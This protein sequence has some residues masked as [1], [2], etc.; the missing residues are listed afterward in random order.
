MCAMMGRGGKVPHR[1]SSE[2]AK[3]RPAASV[4]AKIF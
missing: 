2:K 3:R 4:D 1:G